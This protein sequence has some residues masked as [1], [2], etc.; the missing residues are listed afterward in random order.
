MVTSPARLRNH[1]NS[2][3]LIKWWRTVN[4]DAGILTI[5]ICGKRGS[6]KSFVMLTL[7]NLLDRTADDKSYFSM[8]KISFKASEFLEWLGGDNK[9]W[10][11]GAVICLDDAGLHMY[12]RDSL[13]GFIKKIN[14]T[15]QNIRYKHPIVIL[16]LPS[17]NM[18]DKHARDMT[19]IYIEVGNDR[20]EENREN[21]C[22]I[23][24][25]NLYPYY[26]TLGRQNITAPTERMHP[27]LKIKIKEKS[28]VRYRIEA[29]PRAIIKE[30]ETKKGVYLDKFNKQSVEDLKKEEA[31]MAGEGK[32]KTTF[33][34]KVK[35]CREYFKEQIES[36]DKVGVDDLMSI[37][38]DKGMQMFG[39]S[40]AKAIITRL[41]KLKGSN[42][43]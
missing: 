4:D 43:T 21:F 23:Q 34:E 17:F 9:R 18:L 41:N 28:A 37:D 30:Y 7:A 12:N 40:H 36:G 11:R 6:G 2:S 38:D 10:R 8:D 29:P 27:T 20:D 19:D 42:L 31:K 22:K 3:L 16:T 1:R 13:T 5:V 39:I 14:K 32:K 26:G 15:L 33:N 35:F 25:L 24:E